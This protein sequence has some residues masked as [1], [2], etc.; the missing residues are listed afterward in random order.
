MVRAQ[1]DESS[2]LFSLRELQL[3]EKSRV[4][5]EVVAVRD[6]EHA[7]VRAREEAERRER[8]EQEAWAQA[9]RE[10][11]R[12]VEEAHLAAEREARMRV[13]AAEAA[14]QARAQVELDRQRLQDEMELRRAEV[15]KKRPT[16]MLVVTGLALAAAVALILFANQ[17]MNQSDEDKRNKQ[18]AEQRAQQA[19]AD[20][21][22]AHRKLESVEKDLEELEG[23]MKSTQDALMAAQNDA[24][25]QAARTKL[26]ALQQ[27]EQ[28]AREHVRQLRDAA[29][30][31]Q[32]IQPINTSD[33]C[34][35]APL[36]KGCM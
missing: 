3:I 5:E 25:R 11:Q 21:K 15:A 31:I 13:E 1:R 27:Q 9:E 22:E 8:A 29:E 2:V 14:E 28:A 24:D 17:K 6:A 23:T 7:R 33:V 19:I 12:S 32:R 16:W 10:H 34:R 36:A 26:A 35:N 30:H 4:E 18:V 20:S